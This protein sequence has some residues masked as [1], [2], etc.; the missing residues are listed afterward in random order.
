MRNIKHQKGFTLLELLISMTI[1]L[2]VGSLVFSVLIIS[3]R[4]T[5][6][7]NNTQ[8]VRQNGNDVITQLSRMVQFSQSFNGVSTDGT[9]YTT[10]CQAPIAGGKLQTYEYVQITNFDDGVTTFSCSANP[11]TI[12][13]NSAS[14]IDTNNYT[15]SSCKFTCTQ[16]TPESPQT[17]GISFTLGKKN[18][19]SFL[20]NPTPIEFTTSVTL[21]NY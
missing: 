13:S 4:S 15:I 17:I 7:V 9:T 8:L 16:V 18:A 11:S 6:K 1:L 12:A 19:T 10:A 5:T 14:L 3:I 2:T 20:D 21:R